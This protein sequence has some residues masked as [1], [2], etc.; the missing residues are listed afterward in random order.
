MAIG[1]MKTSQNGIDLIKQFE[2]CRLTAYKDIVGVWTI[3]Y[4]HTGSDVYSGLKITQAKAESLLKADLERFEKGVNRL[5]YIYDFNQNEFDALVSFSYNLGVGCLNQL[6]NNGMRSRQ[7]IRSKWK[8]YCN[9]GG[10][11][12]QGLY[13]R[14]AKELELFNKGNLSTVEPYLIPDGSCVLKYNTTRHDLVKDLQRALNDFAG[15]NLQVDGKFGP[16]T[17][18]AVMELQKRSGYLV[19]DGKYGKNTAAYLIKLARS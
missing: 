16:N 2:G 8:A 15:F 9:A 12:S 3:G 4:G 6:T 19:V 10:K 13:N 18:K 17:R 7:T 1:H 11:Y 14:R 5:D